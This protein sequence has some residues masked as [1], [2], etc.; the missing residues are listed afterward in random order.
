MDTP[1]CSPVGC[2]HRSGAYHHLMSDAC[3]SN[4][5]ALLVALASRLQGLFDQAAADVGLT[6][7]QAQALVRIEAP[8]RLNEL[9]Q[10]QAC[11]PSTITTMVQRLERDGLLQRTVDPL[12][13]RARLVQLTPRG[14]KVRQRF[15]SIV[16]DGSAV[17][18]ALPDE[19]RAALAGLFAAESHDH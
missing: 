18:D 7:A 12:D 11:D 8:S 16:G 14:R 5:L 4:P 19:Q 10:Q 3:E 6:P 13:A 9:A 17:I 2:E 1:S 15:L